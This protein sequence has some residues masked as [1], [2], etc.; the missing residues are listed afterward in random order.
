MYNFI[1]FFCTYLYTIN[2]R[3]IYFFKCMG[4]LEQFRCIGV[5]TGAA[6]AASGANIYI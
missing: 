4:L 2:S 5:H 1:I 6:D 3:K